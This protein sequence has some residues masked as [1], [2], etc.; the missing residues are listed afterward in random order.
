MKKER[1][2]AI[3]VTFNRKDLLQKCLKSLMM[4]TIELDAIFIIDNAST[5]GT[6]EAL[7]D[8]GYLSDVHE[9]MLRNSE[10]LGNNMHSN[11]KEIKIFYVR[12]PQN[13]GGAGGFY[14]GL[15][16]AHEKGFDWY[17]LM[18]D[19]VEME[20][21]ALET[22]LR[23]KERGDLILPRK[24]YY[25]GILYQ[26]S[27]RCNYFSGYR[28]NIFKYFLFLQQS[29]RDDMR[30]KMIDFV[31]FEGLLINKKVV[32]KIGYP[33]KDF[34]VFFDDYEYGLRAKSAGFRNLYI[35]EILIKKNKLDFDIFPSFMKRVYS[36]QQI[37]IAFRNGVYLASKTS[38]NK[39]YFLVVTLFL[40]LIIS[41]Y[42]FFRCDLRG[43]IHN[44]FAL[45]DGLSGRFGREKKILRMM[46]SQ[47][48]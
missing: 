45:V 30:E 21:Y 25:N 22:L 27:F 31:C 40:Y 10:E 26:N 28:Q 36:F 9:Y 18:D 11:T 7:K 33:F 16:R 4:Q 32:D 3:V 19:D 48:K 5:D 37:Y 39:F 12:M 6:F 15:K 43:I 42:L 13:I 20:S 17:W 41:I 24:K 1:I 14:V 46:N 23:Y 47:R 35:P 44:F 29:Y 8:A 34:F 2:C 38:K